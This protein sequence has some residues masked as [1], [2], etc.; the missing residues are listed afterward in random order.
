MI[1]PNLNRKHFVL[2]APIDDEYLSWSPNA[3]GKQP[4][5][6]ISMAEC[7]VQTVQLQDILGQVLAAFYNR[8][9][10]DQEAEPRAP[11]DHASNLAGKN[12]ISDADLQMLLNVDGLLSEWHRKLPMHLKVQVYR[13]GDPSTFSS[14][15]ELTRLFGRQARVLETRYDHSSD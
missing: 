10:D 9:Q 7:Y 11:G 8:G 14:D 12:K 6:K 1:Y 3:P 2:P 4:R 15:P 5:G 13:N